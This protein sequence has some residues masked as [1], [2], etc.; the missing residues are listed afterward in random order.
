VLS[1]P[2]EGLSADPAPHRRG[3]GVG[4]A[5]GLPGPARLPLRERQPGPRPALR[6]GAA[7]AGAAPAHK[8]SLVQSGFRQRAA[9]GIHELS[10]FLFVLG[11][12]VVLVALALC[13]AL[14]RLA[15]TLVATEELLLTA[16]DGLRDAL[17][18]VR[19]S[20]ANLD[21]AAASALGGL[22][23]AS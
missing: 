23:M 18:D 13:L 19:G 1:L 22:R 15:G 5:L 16:I 4:P 2:Q 10:L 20:R 12:C 6:A 9:R 21:S 14:L 11:V 17:P 8:I 3:R 7:T